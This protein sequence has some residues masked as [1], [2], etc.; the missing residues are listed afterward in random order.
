[1]SKKEYVI[2]MTVMPW[3][4]EQFIEMTTQL[5]RNSY[6][7]NLQEVDFIFDV[8]FNLSDEIID[9]DK[10]KLPKQYYVDQFN[11]LM[12]RYDWTSKNNVK[13]HEEGSYGCVDKRRESTDNYSDDTNI[14]WLDPDMTI[15][16]TALYY[17]VSTVEAIDSEYYII[18][19]EMTKR[20]DQTWDLLV[21][22]HYNDVN[23]E[24]WIKIDPYQIHYVNSNLDKNIEVTINPTLDK[25]PFGAGGGGVKF[26][27][28]ML[29]LFNN[30]LLKLIRIPENVP[31]Y[32][33][34]DLYTMAGI[35]WLMTKGLDIKQYIIRNVVVSENR[36]YVQ[37][38]DIH[39]K[40]LEVKLSRTAQRQSTDEQNS[41]I[42]HGLLNKLEKKYGKID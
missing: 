25:I 28:G 22:D 19:P 14:I 12:T 5:R 4:M 37:N 27:G 42:L 3:E 18:T 36:Q 21:N 15:P 16:D 40:Y 8:T 31:S 10:S 23:H 9:W 41:K 33:I 38:N 7:L 11:G 6:Y 24:D 32:G 20:W 13:F 26:G 39:K 17:L 1:M 34:E 30:K 29:N 2:S 35:S